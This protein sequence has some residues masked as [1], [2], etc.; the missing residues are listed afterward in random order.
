MLPNY[1]PEA[2]PPSERRSPEH[3]HGEALDQLQAA[4]LH[5]HDFVRYGQP[6]IIEELEC[7]LLESGTG[8]HAEVLLD[9]VAAALMSQGV[10]PERGRP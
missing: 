8:K 7:F 6:Q 1:P 5:L 3:D 9:D 2:A 10:P 4:A